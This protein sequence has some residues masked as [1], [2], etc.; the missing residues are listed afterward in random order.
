MEA[1]ASSAMH[2]P[3]IVLVGEEGAGGGER[4]CGRACACVGWGGSPGSGR[5]GEVEGWIVEGCGWGWCL[6][7]LARK[8]CV[9]NGAGFQCTACQRTR[10]VD[11]YSD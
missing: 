5:Q 9:E 11:A 2:P 10:Q 1:A 3:N 7:W 8:E 4:G 6:R